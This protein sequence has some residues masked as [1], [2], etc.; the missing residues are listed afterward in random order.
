MGDQDTDASHETLP[1][2]HSVKP[3]QALETMENALAQEGKA[4]LDKR[5]SST[6]FVEE[7]APYKRMK[8]TRSR[9]EGDFLPLFVLIYGEIG[10]HGPA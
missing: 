10:T 3:H 2:S 7:L 6:S 8:C 5:A 9:Y 4:S 1:W